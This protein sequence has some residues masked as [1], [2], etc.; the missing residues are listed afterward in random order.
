MPAGSTE[1]FVLTNRTIQPSTTPVGM[2]QLVHIRY[3]CR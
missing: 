3:Q 1:A 2:R